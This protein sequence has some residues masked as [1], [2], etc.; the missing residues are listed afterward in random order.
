M[1][2]S[3]RTVQVGPFELRIP[4][5][6]ALDQD[7]EWFEVQLD[8]Q[9]QRLRIHDYDQVYAVPALY[10]AVVYRLLRCNSPDV[11]VGLLAEK[12]AEHGIDPGEL[13]VFDAGA[14]NGVVGERLQQHG[15]RRI[16]GSDI[17]PEAGAAARRD[18]GW[19]YDDYVVADLTALTDAQARTLREASFNGLTAVGALGFGD[20][21]PEAFAT[22]FN[23]VADDGWLAFNINERFLSDP[24]AGG[25]SG[26][27][28]GM[29]EKQLM[30]MEVYRRYQHRISFSGQPRYYVAVVA[31]KL[32]DLPAGGV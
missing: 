5:D 17:I 14:G 28:R 12:L 9:W 16:I 18:R 2:E 7:E 26:L 6:P 1:S 13:R 15:I 20:M 29:I 10:E 3:T 27:I 24:E 25:F 4:A 31:R 32:A 11:V 19:V 22:A 8:G 30:R 23:L 21:P